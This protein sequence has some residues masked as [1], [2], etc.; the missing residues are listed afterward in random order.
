M[1]IL[2]LLEFSL[3]FGFL[4]ASL[5][6]G[7]QEPADRIF[8]LD[9]LSN[10][11]PGI[12]YPEDHLGAFVPAF[13][14]PWGSGIHQNEFYPEACK[15]YE[16]TNEITITAQRDQDGK[17]IT[18]RLE[19]HNV[20]STASIEE[21]KKHGY[22]EV[23]STLPAKEDGQNFKG[24]LPGIYLLG[25]GGVYWPKHGEIDIALAMNGYPDIEMAL[26]STN[27]Y[28]GYPQH[29]PLS[30]IHMSA[31][32][33]RDPLAAGLEWNVLEDEGKIVLNWW[34]SWFDQISESWVTRNTS[35]ALIEGTEDD[36]LDFYDSFTTDGFSLT[37]DLPE[38]G[39][40]APGPVLVDGQPQYMHI[41][42]V[43]VYGFP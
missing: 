20:W 24:S 23:E 40:M 27:H 21:I 43:K 30:P 38:G 6:K 3:N 12:S 16:V 36:Y 18:G 28:G 4:F 1:L 42:S 2:A 39:P 31:D 14:P 15:Q 22:I 10:T 26:H 9:L 8:K 41:S 19:T 33:S 34:I 32:L 29:P 7:P 35:K 37:I 5:S 17:V 11:Q 13:V 25:L